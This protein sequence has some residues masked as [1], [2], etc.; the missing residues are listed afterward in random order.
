M[1]DIVTHLVNEVYDGKTDEFLGY[2]TFELPTTEERKLLQL[3]NYGKIP[4]SLILL[5]VNFSQTPPDYVPPKLTEK[6]K[7]RGV[8]RALFRDKASGVF[9]PV[10]I[11]FT[12]D[13]RGRGN[14]SGDVYHFDSLEYSNIKV[15]QINQTQSQS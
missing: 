13:V 14:L 6:A 1:Y 15:D 4:E 7:R 8:L 2:S 5:N 11:H 10:D 12:F 9:V 3:V